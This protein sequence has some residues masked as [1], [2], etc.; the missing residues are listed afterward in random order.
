ML[1]KLEEAVKTFEQIN[2]TITAP[3][4]HPL[5]IA[6]DAHRNHKLS[7]RFFIFADGGEIF[8]HGFHLSPIN[9]SDFFDIQSPYGYGGPAATSDNEEFLRKAWSAYSAWSME[10]KILAEFVRFHPLLEN[11]RYYDG[12]II[13]NRQTVWIDLRLDLSLSNYSTRVRTAIRKAL[14][15][16]LR[17]EWW[18]S[19]DFIKVFPDMYHNLM[20]ELD[21]DDF[22]YL[23][24]EYFKTLLNWDK[25]YNAVCIYENQI[26][27]GAVFFHNHH[28]MEYH[29]SAANDQGKKLS[30]TNLLLHEAVRQGQKLG[31]RFLHLGGGTDSSPDN[32]L[33]FFKSGFSKQRASFKIG[34]KINFKEQYEQMKEDHLRKHGQIPGKLLFYR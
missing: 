26:T 15:N 10:N 30:A 20:S 2:N 32:P 23:P 14:K 9:G 25:V 13:D 17:I 18:D 11:W 5:Y 8:Y 19:A 4:L 28:I 22:Y 6:A 24:E 1:V 21:A 16:N 29:L 34:T 31:C 27:A 33:L 12:N 3:S 7:P